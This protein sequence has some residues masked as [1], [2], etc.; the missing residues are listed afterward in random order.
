[1]EMPE[2]IYCVR[3]TAS[4][5]FFDVDRVKTAYPEHEGV[6]HHDRTVQRLNARIAELEAI[7][8]ARGE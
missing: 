3:T 4:G 5:G 7:L 8:E 2:K 1:M 6:Y